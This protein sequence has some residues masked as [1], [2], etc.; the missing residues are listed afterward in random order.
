MKKGS[1]EQR[2]A[3]GRARARIQDGLLLALQAGAVIGLAV[4]APNALILLKY[5]PI[6]QQKETIGKRITQARSRLIARGLVEK[7]NDHGTVR[8]VLTSA[9]EAYAQKI[10]LKNARN[11]TPRKWDGLWRIVIFDVWESRRNV[12][13]ALRVRLKSTGFIQLQHSVWV[14][15]YP[16]EEF[17]VYARIELKLG[18]SLVYIVANEIENDKK[19]RVHFRLPVRR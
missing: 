19:L 1:I 16:C 10:E 15:P 13:D 12:R 8:F 2:I 4:S 17:I 18:P 14:Y 9:G 5:L 7:R 3:Q 11:L 6:Q